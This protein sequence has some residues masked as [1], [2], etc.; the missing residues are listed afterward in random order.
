MPIAVP[1]T[2]SRK[3]GVKQVIARMRCPPPDS[4]LVA[5][6]RGLRWRGVP[7]N[8]IESI[9]KASEAGLVCVEVDLRLTSDG[10]VVVFHDD[11]LGRSTN[12]AEHFGRT[13]LYSP[14]TGRGYN[15]RVEDLPWKGVVQKL[16]LKEEHGRISEEGVLD[17][18]G[19]LD[20]MGSTHLDMV[21][22]LDLKDRATLDAAVSIV[23]RSPGAEK[24]CLLK[25]DAS[26]CADPDDLR[27]A[28][29][30]QIA[31]RDAEPL[32]VP[33]YRPEACRKFDALASI[34]GYAQLP[35]VVSFEI[36]LR[37]PGGFLKVL[38]DFVRSGDCPVKGMGFF[39]SY[40]DFHPPDGEPVLFEG[41]DAKS[42]RS[43]AG[44]ALAFVENNVPRTFDELLLPG[45]SPD[46]HDHR[47]DIAVY[48]SMGYTWVITDVPDVVSKEQ[49]EE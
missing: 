27:D 26:W 16:K 25:F 44:S 19:L 40:G 23:A 20:F 24:C 21:V 49:G 3:R 34:K 7:D 29:W 13:D 11:C 45:D 33:V 47:A 35:N 15:P 9:I 43:H 17:L 48:R 1:I 37:G 30:Y 5:A 38:V 8:S 41:Y 10:H 6:H 31:S 2:P 42:P 22:L 46:G 36:G 32:L 18:Q 14:F 4:F 12:V 28:A 39:A